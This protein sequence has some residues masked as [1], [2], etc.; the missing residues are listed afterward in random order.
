MSV[1]LYTLLDRRKLS[2]PINI[3][4]TVS[5]QRR[6]HVKQRDTN[7]RSYWSRCN[8][9]QV[10]S[11]RSRSDGWNTEPHRTHRAHAHAVMMSRTRGTSVAPAREAIQPT[12]RD[13][14]WAG[15]PPRTHFQSSQFLLI[16]IWA[17]HYYTNKPRPPPIHRRRRRSLLS[18]CSFVYTRI[19]I[20][21][22]DIGIRPRAAAYIATSI[23]I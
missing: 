17:L 22:V 16:V 5:K 4:L 10:K 1:K 14:G 23:T 2:S 19:I 18:F 8:C 15:P 3:V 21:S 11:S 20:V 7:A 6:T 9:S 13:W 12:L